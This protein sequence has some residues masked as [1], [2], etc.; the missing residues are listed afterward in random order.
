MRV[1]EGKTFFHPV[2]HQI[3]EE[4]GIYPGAAHLDYEN[5]QENNEEK[6]KKTRKNSIKSEDNK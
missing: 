6:T 2:T 4:N 1:N 3:I 5:S